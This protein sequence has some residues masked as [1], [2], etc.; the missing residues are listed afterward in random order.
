MTTRP[1]TRWFGILAAAGLAAIAMI[2]EEH[3][4]E[5]ARR[6]SAVFAGRLEELKSQC[7]IIREVRVVGLMIGVELVKNRKTKEPIEKDVA[8]RIEW[9]EGLKAKAR[10]DG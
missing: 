2:E 6:L 9:W 8:K 1:P 7:E 5:R 10:G 4:L 3:L